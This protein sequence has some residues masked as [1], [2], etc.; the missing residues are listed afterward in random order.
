MAESKTESA[1]PQPQTDD[2][3]VKQA[4]SDALSPD[5]KHKNYLETRERLLKES[6]VTVRGG[7]PFTDG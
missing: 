2:E 6:T 4:K 1:R 3:A 5:D 7:Q